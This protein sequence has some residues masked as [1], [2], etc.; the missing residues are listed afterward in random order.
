MTISNNALIAVYAHIAGSYVR[1]TGV[2]T[3]AVGGYKEEK[4][5]TDGLSRFYLGRLGTE[6]RR[7]GG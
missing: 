5:E 4:G 3:I 2:D 1:D 6:E 7:E